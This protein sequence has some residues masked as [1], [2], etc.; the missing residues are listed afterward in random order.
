MGGK[1]GSVIGNAQRR[2]GQW[3]QDL[4]SPPTVLGMIPDPSHPVGS[5]RVER[6]RDR[7]ERASRQ[8]KAPPLLGGARKGQNVSGRCQ[9]VARR[10]QEVFRRCNGQEMLRWNRDVPWCG[11]EGPWH[12]QDPLDE[13]AMGDLRKS[14]A[15][16]LGQHG[17][18]PSCCQ[19]RLLH[20]A[21]AAPHPREPWLWSLMLVRASWH[22]RTPLFSVA[23]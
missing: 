23:I 8:V 10:C 18:S 2:A 19:G 22:F 15:T 9:G 6:G 17:P 13:A 4:P 5:W 11:R 16:G 14:R 21:P 3:G 20:P 1:T 12:I 7:V